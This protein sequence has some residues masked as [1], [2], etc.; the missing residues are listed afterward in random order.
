[1]LDDD[2]VECQQEAFGGE[3]VH[4]DA[5]R[6]LHG[7]AGRGADLGIEAEIQDQFFRGD[8]HPAEIGVDRGQR[9]IIRGDLVGLFLGGLGREGLIFF[10]FVGHR[11]FSLE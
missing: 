8:V 5:V 10:R 6:Q 3:E 9:G 1:M 2:V 4:D 7:F 11:K